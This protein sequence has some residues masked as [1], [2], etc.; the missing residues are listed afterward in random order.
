MQTIETNT[1][2]AAM[3]NSLERNKETHDTKIYTV[4]LLSNWIH[5]RI[6][7]IVIFTYIEMNR[8]Q[9]RLIDASAEILVITKLFRHTRPQSKQIKPK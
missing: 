3:K 7:P 6:T 8:V 5:S 2:I 1:H 9:N 4:L